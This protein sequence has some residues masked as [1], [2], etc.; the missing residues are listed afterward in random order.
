MKPI[1]V[2]NVHEIYKINDNQ[3]AIVKTDRI[4]V[5]GNLLPNPIKDKGIVL[6]KISNFWFDMTKDITGNHIVH[7]ECHYMPLFFQDEFFKHRTILV[8]KLDIIP[9]EFIVRGYIF[10][11]MWKAY[12]N[13]EPFCGKRILGNYQLAEKLKHPVLTPTQKSNNNQDED[14][15]IKDVESQLGSSLTRQIVN[16]CFD[17]YEECSKY[18]LTKG[19]IIADTKF[20]F[21]M[22]KFNQLVLADEIFTPDSSRFWDAADYQ[23][24]ISPKSYDKQLIR[25]WLLHN[26]KNNTYQFNAIPQNVYYKTEMRYKE[27][28]SRIVPQ[29]TL[30]DR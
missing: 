29:Q 25:D 19:L 4:S 8:D 18:A 20:E 15:D 9:F 7:N 23:I 2:G 6:N 28:L 11:R 17:L 1:Y 10:G 3:L 21:G 26:K 12:K 14:V 22:N 27:C 5:F 16:I 30:L 24:G 13:N